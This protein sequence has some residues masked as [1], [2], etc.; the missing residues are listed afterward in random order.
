MDWIHHREKW[1]VLVNKVNNHHVPQNIRNSQ[2]AKDL[3]FFKKLFSMKLAIF[4]CP[5]KS[6]P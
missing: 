2:E 3:L 6:N 1:Q 4:R 5:A